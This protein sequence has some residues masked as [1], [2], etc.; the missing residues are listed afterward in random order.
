M[1]FSPTRLEGVLLI[2]PTVHRDERGFFLES[3]KSKDFLEAGIS[4][5]F[6]QDNHTKSRGG[7]LRGLHAQ[8]RKAQGKLIRV[9]QGE[10][11]DVAVDA[12]PDSTTF[13]KWEGH[14]LSGDNFLQLYVPRGFLHGF[15]V[16][17]PTAEVE[18]RC[19]D[20]YD[21]KDEIGV[22]WNDPELKIPWPVSPPLLSEK[23]KGLRTFA[24]M[25]KEFE[26]YRGIK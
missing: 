9:T 17:S 11:F 23:D 10:I 1:R 21:A 13:G 14:K 25:G 3:Y 5:P 6:V 19:T 16:L 20:Y 12:R 26:S 24:E 2:E 22:A 18:Y 7:T 4:L 15:C 8:L